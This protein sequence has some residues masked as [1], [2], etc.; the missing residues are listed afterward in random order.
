MIGICLQI[1]SFKIHIISYKPSI[2]K[3]EGNTLIKKTCSEISYP[4]SFSKGQ[5]T[6]TCR[7]SHISKDTIIAE[8]TQGNQEIG[9]SNT[10][11]LATYRKN[12][13][14]RSSEMI[15]ADWMLTQICLFCQ[16]LS[17][18]WNYR[19]HKSLGPSSSTGSYKR[20][21]CKQIP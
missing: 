14:K 8:S 18:L 3:Q 13:W 1:A 20:K 6:E 16:L 15:S 2:E 11:R 9:L 19:N 5:Q 10:N 17:Y 21:N 4:I 12:I 7:H